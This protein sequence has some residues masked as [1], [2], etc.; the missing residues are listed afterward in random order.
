MYWIFEIKQKPI[1]RRI[2]NLVMKI[3]YFINSTFTL[4]L[5][6]LQEDEIKIYVESTKR[7]YI[8]SIKYLMIRRYL[9]KT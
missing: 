4:T 7:Y 1:N 3:R 9:K 8:Y 6:D 2:T 5:F